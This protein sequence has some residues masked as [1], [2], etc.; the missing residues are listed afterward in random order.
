MT[1]G[2]SAMIYG[3]PI[4]LKAI[5]GRMNN[6]ARTDKM[7]FIKATVALT[8]ASLLITIPAFAQTAG[9]SNTSTATGRSDSDAAGAMKSDSMKS[10]DVKST[11]TMKPAANGTSTLAGP[12]GKTS[13]PANK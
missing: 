5:S 13:D 12:A 2:R 3:Q 4:C 10:G 7:S 6:I 9:T 11:G 8:A 1:I